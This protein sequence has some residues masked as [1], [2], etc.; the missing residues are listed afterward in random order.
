MIR[1]MPRTNET[2]VVPST[3]WSE[4]AVCKVDGALP[5]AQI[6]PEL[7]DI[8][9]AVCGGLGAFTV[10]LAVFEFPNILSTAIN[11]CTEAIR[12]TCYSSTGITGSQITLP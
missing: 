3:G 6:I 12:P 11:S 4:T 2:V 5:I 7:S 10:T 9:I 1:D 8:L